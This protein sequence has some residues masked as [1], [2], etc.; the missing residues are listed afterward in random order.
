MGQSAAPSWP[1]SCIPDIRAL[2][3]PIHLPEDDNTAWKISHHR[4]LF[5]FDKKVFLYLRNIQSGCPGDEQVY[6]Y[7]RLKIRFLQSLG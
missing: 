6:S 5:M 7:T 2:F 1:T 4:R 3:L